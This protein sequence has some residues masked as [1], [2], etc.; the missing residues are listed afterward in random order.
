[1]AKRDYYDVLGVAKGAEL[2]AIK[3]AYLSSA[4]D[5]R[6]FL[7]LT[8]VTIRIGRKAMTLGG[9]SS[10]AAIARSSAIQVWID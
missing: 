5:R 1:M 4:S 8:R 7:D 10:K 6:E 3:K 2:D 9:D